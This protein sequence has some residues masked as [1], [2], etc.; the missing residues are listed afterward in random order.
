[1]EIPEFCNYYDQNYVSTD[2][3]HVDFATVAKGFGARSYTATTLDEVRDALAKETNPDGPAV[4]DIISDQW[5]T[6]VQ[7]L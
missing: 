7:G 5:E 1:M 2:F 4:I 3:S 6:P